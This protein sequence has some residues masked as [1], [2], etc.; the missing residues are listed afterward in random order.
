MWIFYLDSI[1][2]I[3]II[4]IKDYRYMKNMDESQIILYKL[5]STVIN[6]KFTDFSR[7]PAKYRTILHSDTDDNLN[8]FSTFEELYK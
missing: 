2:I 7:I 4:Y 1:G 3:K 8:N 5:N 6:G